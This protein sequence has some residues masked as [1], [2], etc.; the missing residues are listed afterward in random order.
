M[1]NYMHINNIFDNMI[2][3]VEYIKNASFARRFKKKD[4]Q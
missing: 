1:N 3:D 4:S 2:E